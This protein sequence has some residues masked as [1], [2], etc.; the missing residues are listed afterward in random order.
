MIDQTRG[1]RR[2]I[3]LLRKRHRGLR[4]W[5]RLLPPLMPIAVFLYC[6]FDK[7]L[8]L[9]GRAGMFYTLQRFS[10]EAA[11]SLMILEERL[12]KR[13]ERREDQKDGQV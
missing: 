3:N 2:E 9:S 10:A 11:L 1:M 12:R 5:L 13:T 8:I 4:A 7:G 6:L